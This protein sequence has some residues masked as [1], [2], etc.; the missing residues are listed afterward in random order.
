MSA[1]ITQIERNAKGKLVFLCF[2]SNAQIHNEIKIFH[3]YLESSNI[4]SIFASDKLKNYEYVTSHR[5]HQTG[6]CS[7]T[8]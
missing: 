4:L 1:K 3:N 7:S 2:S 8:S 6:C 5:E